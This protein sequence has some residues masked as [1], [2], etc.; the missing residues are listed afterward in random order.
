M[1]KIA[2]D[3]IATASSL[4]VLVF[5]FTDMHTLS[6]RS[7]LVLAC[8]FEVNIDKPALSLT[9]TYHLTVTQVKL[10]RVQIHAVMSETKSLNT[11]LIQVMIP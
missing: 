8:S 6:H 3:N 5:N 2:S 4:S 11:S 10:P 1:D 7:A 9:I